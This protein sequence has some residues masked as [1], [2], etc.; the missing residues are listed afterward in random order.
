MPFLSTFN[1]ADAFKTTKPCSLFDFYQEPWH[2]PE[3]VFVSMDQKETSKL[4]QES[5]HILK[6]SP[7][8]NDKNN[9]RSLS[10]GVK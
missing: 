9:I 7:V 6:A 8:W 4:N 10:D 1:G 3:V 5:D 2:K